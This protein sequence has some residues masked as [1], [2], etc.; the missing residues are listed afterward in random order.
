[1]DAASIIVLLMAIEVMYPGKRMIRLFVD[2]AGYH[3][4]KLVQA[5]LAHPGRW[6]KLHFIPAYCPHLDPIERLWWLMHK[7]VT[8]N[9]VMRR[10]RFPRRDPDVPARGGAEK[11]AHLLR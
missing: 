7:H 8:H 2:N 6:I 3:H 10:R 4:A 1:M 9:D 5:W 11:V